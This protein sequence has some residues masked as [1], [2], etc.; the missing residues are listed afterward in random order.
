ML[1]CS[2]GQQLF[3]QTPLLG[4]PDTIEARSGSDNQVIADNRW[5]GQATR[6]ERVLGKHL[7]LC[8]NHMAFSLLIEAVDSIFGNDR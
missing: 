2:D 6:I 4:C 8:I 3:F 7:T 5:R 1:A